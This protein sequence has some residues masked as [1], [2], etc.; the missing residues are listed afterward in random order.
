MKL[1]V[2]EKRKYI[3]INTIFPVEFRLVNNAYKPISGWIQGFSRDVGKGGMRL[4]VNVISWIFWDKIKNN[5]CR[6]ELRIHLPFSSYVINTFS[7]IAWAG[8]S[9][10]KA[11][12]NFYIGLSFLDIKSSDRWK[13]IRFAYGKNITPK[14]VIVA[15]VI[16]LSFF[17]HSLYKQ[18]QVVKA[19][20]KVVRELT[21]VL[22]ELSIRRRSLD[23][24]RVVSRFL[25]EKI[26]DLN[27]K[28]DST[29]AE[30]VSWQEQYHNLEKEKES[31]QVQDLSYKEIEDKKRQ[32]QEKIISLQEELE[33]LKVNNIELEKRVAHL[34]SL[35]LES[36]ESLKNIIRKKQDLSDTAVEDM[37]KWI[38]VRQNLKTGLVVSFEGDSD[39]TGWGF[40]YDQALC[41]NVFV[42]F[43]DYT[44]AE[45]IMDFYLTKAKS[46]DGGFLNAYYVSDGSACE[47]IVHSGP[48]LWLG[49]SVLRY[50]E[51]TGNRKYLPI[52]E[53]V[54]EFILNIQDSEGGIKGGP[55][56]SWYATEHNLDAFSFFRDIYELTFD[57][58]YKKAQADV[59]SWLE[60]YSYTQHDIPINRGKGDSTIAT[61]TYTWSIAALGPELLTAIGMDP[62]GIIDFAVENCKIRTFFKKANQ[63]IPVEGFDFARIRHL[64]R[65]G[66]IS[67]EWSAQMVLSLKILSDFYERDSDYQKAKHY[68]D[69]SLYYLEELSKMIISSPSP[70]GQGK[71]CLPYAS[72][73]SVDT[74]HGWTTPAGNQTCSVAATAYYIFAYTGY[75]PLGP[76]MSSVTLSVKDE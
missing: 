54:A 58:R 9:R 29:S 62:E 53:K 30:L 60:R 76:Q 3:R 67:C 37:Y 55:T 64:P 20:Q 22:E 21:E 51:A 28:V 63:K 26:E 12:G 31:L 70:T 45:R 74:G 24:N 44:A 39:L 46:H 4:F 17:A 7:Y 16:L 8:K 41:L 36:E 48:N 71:G 27:R 49:L 18:N 69:V 66:V 13:L 2:S 56:V 68:R 5:K 50:I 25:Q 75:N 6:L 43:K 15:F 33:D 40:T 11:E 73:G 57:K 23:Q 1:P 72:Q 52:A 38:K 35:S 47:Y 65:G 61:D 34:Q 19:N 42:L 14:A 10:D 59:R 32:A